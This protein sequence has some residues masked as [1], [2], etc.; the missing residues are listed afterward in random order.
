RLR[1]KD[2]VP[3]PVEHVNEATYLHRRKYANAVQTAAAA[4]FANIPDPTPAAANRADECANDNRRR[5]TRRRQD[6]RP[7]P[8]RFLPGSKRRRHR[9]RVR[10]AETGAVAPAK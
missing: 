4:S 7:R 9:R 1:R 3:C 5:R 6:G 8:C 2:G 10:V